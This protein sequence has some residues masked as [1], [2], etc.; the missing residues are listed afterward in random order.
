M[1]KNKAPIRS[2]SRVNNKYQPHS[3][4][5]KVDG[6]AATPLP[7]MN[8]LQHECSIRQSLVFGEKLVA[9]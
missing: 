5:W 4:C 7:N 2:S 8:A 9:T 3:F 1:E 6:G